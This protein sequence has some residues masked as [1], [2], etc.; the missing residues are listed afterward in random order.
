MT[1]NQKEKTLAVDLDCICALC[2]AMEAKDPGILGHSERVARTAVELA[3]QMGIVES[4][5]EKIQIA[6][7]AHDIG[8]IGISEN[9]LNKE[10]S[11]S[12]AEYSQIQRHP[13]IAERILAS[14]I[15]EYQIIEMIR[16]HH[17]RYDGLGYPDGLDGSETSTG[18]QILAV[19]DAF[20]AMTSDRPYRKALT[21][22][23]ALAEINRGNGSQFD[24]K[25][26][27]R[28]VAML[29]TSG[30]ALTPNDGCL[31]AGS[32]LKRGGFN[33]RLARKTSS[34]SEPFTMKASR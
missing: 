32:Y 8:K 19:C 17:E 22:S 33:I 1:L 4:D 34:S 25:I 26:A 31:W 7:I 10:T 11:L 12:R 13:V 14:V 24:P 6:A 3:R 20:D 28:F 9:I 21:I 2:A 29:T 5:I 15:H 23:Q 27:E 18:A 30:S 16:H